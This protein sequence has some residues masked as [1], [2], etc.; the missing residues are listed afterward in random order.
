MTTKPQTTP[1]GKAIY[2]HLSKPDYAFDTNGKYHVLL[3]LTEE[4]AQPHIDIINDTIKN[5]VVEEHKKNGNKE[6]KRA[7]LPYKHEDGKVR[8]N[9]KMIASG[10]NSKTKQTFTQKPRI[11][12]HN[13]EPFDTEKNIW[14][15]SI[16]RITYQPFGYSNSA[17]GV[18]CTLRLK[19]VQ[20]KHLVE[21]DGGG[22]SFTKVDPGDTTDTDGK[23]AHF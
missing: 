17:I 12:D 9:F 15:D 2:P 10:I 8:L 4:E 18:G 3:E 7:P 21:G 5:I 16:L 22:N 19:E 14:G 13:L 20:V 23:V 6:V 1:F 11:Y